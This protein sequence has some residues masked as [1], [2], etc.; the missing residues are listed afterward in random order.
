MLPWLYETDTEFFTNLCIAHKNTF[1]TACRWICGQ[2]Y[3]VLA[4]NRALVHLNSL[5]LG[6]SVD[7]I[8]LLLILKDFF[9]AAFPQVHP[10]VLYAFITQ[11][12]YFYQ[13]SLNQLG[14]FPEFGFFNF[15]KVTKGKV[16]IRVTESVD[17]SWKHTKL[18]V[19]KSFRADFLY[20]SKLI[21]LIS[22]ASIDELA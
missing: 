1:S 3:R 12:Q 19:M 15:E 11:L 16:R 21:T 13:C 5:F 20:Q 7:G 2:I 14:N 18:W 8:D 4:I 6:Q 10:T 17:K 22:I 9:M